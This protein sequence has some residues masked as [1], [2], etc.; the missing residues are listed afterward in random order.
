V[1]G[2]NSKHARVVRIA[3]TYRGTPPSVGRDGILCHCSGRGSGRGNR[4]GVGVGSPRKAPGD[5][6]PGS[7][8]GVRSR[9]LTAQL[10]ALLRDI[11]SRVDSQGLRL[12]YVTDEGYHP[13]ITI[14]RAQED[15]R[16]SPTLASSGV[17]TGSS[18]SIMPAN[19]FSNWRTRF[20][21]LGQ[22]AQ[23]WASSAPRVKNES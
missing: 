10:S 8:A 17:E 21:G 22:K 5:C 3:Y 4:H 6:L 12:V 14:S 13:A 16:P 20:S 1:L 7:H 18:I 23:S 11:L 9:E 15:D 2:G 19:T